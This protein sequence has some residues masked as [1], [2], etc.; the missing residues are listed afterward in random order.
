MTLMDVSLGDHFAL[1][2]GLGQPLLD[3]S[4]LLGPYSFQSI[5]VGLLWTCQVGAMSAVR[6]HVDL[7]ND[8][9]SAFLKA[10]PSPRI[11]ITTKIP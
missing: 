2:R 9:L 7:G 8:V 6:T 5:G 11:C 4:E 10:G 1:A 3:A